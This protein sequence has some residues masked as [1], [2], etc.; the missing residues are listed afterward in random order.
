MLLVA[1]PVRSLAELKCP[2]TRR[3]CAA[4]A[5]EHL[6]VA[7]AVVVASWPPLAG[8]LPPRKLYSAGLS[9]CC[10]LLALQTELW[11]RGDG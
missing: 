3:L 6:S 4:D 9:R 10:C 7:A 5:T 1:L 11:A 8:A 2:G